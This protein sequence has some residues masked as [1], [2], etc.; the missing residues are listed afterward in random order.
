[1]TQTRAEQ[2]FNLKAVNVAARHIQSEQSRGK[3]DSVQT[4]QTSH[5]LD[6]LYALLTGDDPTSPASGSEGQVEADYTLL[7]GNMVDLGCGQGDQT[8]VLAAVLSN[9]PERYKESKTG[10]EML[11]ERSFDTV[12]LS[13]SSWYFP[14]AQVLTASFKSI[15]EA[16]V[17]HLLLAEWAMT[18]SHPN[19]LPHL[20]SVLLQGQSPVEGGN[21]QTALSPEQM[22]KVAADSGWKVKRELTFL[23]AEKLQD[24]G[25]E[26]YM[27][28]EAAHEAAKADAGGDEVKAKLLQLVQATRYAME[29]A[30]ARYGKQTRS[31]DVWT[32]VLIP[33]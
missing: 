22:K 14:S 9:N 16:G 28:R 2:F 12:F 5:R 4:I 13:H 17:K 6:I 30:A 8:G 3:Q 18:A 7:S 23:P 33:A 10:P 19:A 21:V 15:R 11:K 26:V 20:L 29:E 25:W 1:M 24:G 31:M 27:A 32:A